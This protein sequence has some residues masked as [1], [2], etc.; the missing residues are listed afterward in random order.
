MEWWNGTVTAAVAEAK[1]ENTRPKLIAH[2][3]SKADEKDRRTKKARSNSLASCAASSDLTSA[4]SFKSLLAPTSTPFTLRWSEFITCGEGSSFVGERVW[5]ET[6]VLCRISF[7]HHVSARS[8]YNGEKKTSRNQGTWKHSS[9]H[10]RQLSND[11]AT[12]TSYT[13]MIIDEFSHYHT[14]QPWHEWTR[15]RRAGATKRTAVAGYAQRK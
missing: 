7:P 3:E 13:A 6:D 2:N 12:V 11:L 10:L 1:N 8:S 9:I 14:S 5:K 15:V 4:K